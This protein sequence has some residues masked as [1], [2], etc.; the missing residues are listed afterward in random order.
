VNPL[1]LRTTVDER[2]ETILVL[3][4]DHLHERGVDPSSGGDRVET[5]DDEIELFV[6]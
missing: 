2:L 1:T 3:L 4:V 6:E 5:G